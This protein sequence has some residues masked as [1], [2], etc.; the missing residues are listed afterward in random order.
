MKW[1]K[2]KDA[3]IASSGWATYSSI[4]SI[5]PDAKLDLVEIESLLDLIAE[6]IHQTDGRVAYTMNGFL[7]S[8]GCY[9]L[10]LLKKTKQIAKKIGA[11]EIDLGN[12]ACKVPLATEYIAKVESTSRI[13]QKRK[14]SRC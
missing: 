6:K 9:V 2:S 1:M 14:T 10:P 13:G 7:I 5:T 3:K 8:V 11:V 12:T 4:V